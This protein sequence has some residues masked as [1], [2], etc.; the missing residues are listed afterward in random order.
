VNNLRA[1]PVKNLRFPGYPGKLEV[2]KEPGLLKN[3]VP[4]NWLTH[5]ELTGALSAFLAFNAVGYSES[6]QTT[7]PTPKNTNRPAITAPLFQQGLNTGNMNN[8]PRAILG[9]VMI[10][11]PAYLSEAEAM[12]I[13]REEMNQAGLSKLDSKVNMNKVIIEGREL[14]YGYNWVAGKYDYRLVEVSG[15]LEADLTDPD[16]HI[17]IEYVSRED[18]YTLGGDRQSSWATDLNKTS[19]AL[20]EQVREQDPDLHFASFF[21]PSDNTFQGTWIQR[22]AE[23][24]RLLRLQV[25]DFVDWLKGQGVI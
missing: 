23:S 15:P 21:D 1:K 5:R 2:L 8:N 10:S 22:Q 19:S 18:F 20:E 3:H 16:R 4:R 17:A 11:P 13:I 25:K 9:C 24:K 14:K 7:N 12:Q 6:P